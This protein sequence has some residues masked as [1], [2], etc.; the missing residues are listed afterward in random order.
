MLEAMPTPQQ[1]AKLRR[2]RLRQLLT[3]H[4]I[5]LASSPPASRLSARRAAD[6]KKELVKALMS[7]MGVAW[8]E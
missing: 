7:R 3:K 4:H 6:L 2:S 5:E 8:Q 1:G